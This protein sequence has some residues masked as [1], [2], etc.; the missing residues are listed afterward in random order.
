LRAVTL[1]ATLAVASAVAAAAIAS[2]WRTTASAITPT[3]TPTATSVPAPGGLLIDCDVVTPGIQTS[4]TIPAGGGAIDVDVILVS[5]LARMIAAFQ[6]RAVSSD[7][8]RLDGIAIPDAPPSYN[9]N[10][11][12]DESL[13]GAAVYQCGAPAPV[14][15]VIG[16]TVR[17][18]L[19]CYSGLLFFSVG[20]NSQTKLA[21]VHYV[22]PPGAT[23]GDVALSLQDAAVYD[24]DNIVEAFSCNPDL[25]F[26]GACGTATIHLLG[27]P[28]S[29][30]PTPTATPTTPP[31]A[32]PTSVAVGATAT[33]TPASAVYAAIDCDT[34]TPGIQVV[35]TYPQSVGAIDVGLVF[36]NNGAAPVAFDA[37]TAVILNPDR[38][39][40]VPL[41]GVDSAQDGNPDL[42]SAFP[43]VWACT[44]PPIPDNGSAGPT[45][46]LSVLNCISPV[47]PGNSVPP[48]TAFEF[49]RMHYGVPPGADPG[50]V[51]VD[52]SKPGGFHTEFFGDG[53]SVGSCDP[54]FGVPMPCLSATINLVADPGIA[55]LPEGNAAN[56]DLSVPKANLWL[57]Q[58]PAACAGPGEGD[59]RVV[60]HAAAV[61]SDY[62]ADGIA[63]AGDPDI[64][65]TGLANTELGL[66]AYE[67]AVEYDN[68]VIQ[69]L[70]P[71]DIVFG[72][73]G[74]GASRGPVDEVNASSPA[75]A[76]CAPD[77]GAGGGTCSMSFVL[78]NLVRFG[79][80]TAGQAQGPSGAMDLASL[81]LVPHPDLANDIFPGNNNGVL[82]VLKDNSCELADRLGHPMAGSL[83]GG[84]TQRCGDLAVTVRILEGDLNLDCHVD[85]TDE[86]LISFRY[87]G[88][89]GGLQ[90]QKWYDI[91]P[92]TH[93][94]DIDI[95]DLQKV[96]GRDDS[97]C[98]APLPAQPP[99]DPPAPFSD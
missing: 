82:T 71:C 35:C 42:S 41:P 88:F 75:N 16:S 99:L 64:A 31:T 22:V 85:V 12:V 2:G 10:P 23:A 60:E 21:T 46:S 29:A 19:D 81:V 89:F 40:L 87:G 77:P 33:T 26:P 53:S 6:F 38:S 27:P 57:C 66:G 47:N 62:D 11:D 91:E 34:S 51:T 67:F 50:M 90:Y 92:A 78:E 69:S 58:A 52:L 97:S 76:D 61:F 54:V 9:S 5:S 68:L 56:A 39:R 49:A 32:T 28:A 8:G 95:K 4:C 17:N 20:A 3:P 59:L 83:N 13:F 73:G 55:K 72:P 70:N 93:D 79:C 1:A 94:L 44:P 86:Q 24:G 15:D 30:S 43:L 36:V 96:F 45:A 80:V 25:F 65:G 74:A 63:D 18:L 7:V 14:R 37:L 48:F 98:Q 84:L